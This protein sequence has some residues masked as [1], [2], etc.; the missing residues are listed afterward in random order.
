M[1][2]KLKKEIA[3]VFEPPKSLNKD[4]FIQK[5]DYPKITRTEFLHI[6][7]GYIR[8][9]VWCIFFLLL[10][11]AITCT[12]LIGKGDDIFAVIG[13]ISA[14]V[15]FLALVM[16]AEIA[17]S[18]AFSMAEIE[19]TT[20]FQLSDIVLARMGIL[21]TGTM[22]MFLIILPI[23]SRTI[24][25][26]IVKTGIY[27]LVPYLLICIISLVIISHMKGKDV[28]FYCGVSSV[29]V[30]VSICVFG[31]AK[32]TMMYSEQYFNIWIFIFI[33]SIFI[34]MKQVKQYIRKT[35]ELEWNLYLMD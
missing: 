11:V 8:K 15:P 23:I 17:R 19:M 13:M 26:G 27:I 35:E 25:L 30:S 1:N 21:G 34:V 14:I 4:E 2:K 6:Q 22:I 3:S 33:I 31:Y 9:R 29:L 12:N 28:A 10:T 20:R 32:Y 7:M 16:I 24:G 18:A 5:L